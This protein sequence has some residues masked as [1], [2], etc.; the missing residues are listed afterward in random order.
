[1][2]RLSTISCCPLLMVYMTLHLA[3]GGIYRKSHLK[4]FGVPGYIMSPLT[5]PYFS[6][7]TCHLRN[8]QC[9]GHP[10][11][12][13]LPVPVYH[14]V[15]MDQVLRF[16]RSQ[17]IY[18]HGFRLSRR[19]VH[20]YVCK[21]RL[22]QHGLLHEAAMIDSYGEDTLGMDSNAP[23]ADSE[24][25]EEGNASVDST[26]KAREKFVAAALRTTKHRGLGSQKHE[27][28]TQM[29]RM[30]I[31][32]FL[33]D[34]VKSG[35]CA[36][37]QGVSPAYRK[38][39]FVKIFE[40][41]LSR[42]DKAMMERKNLRPVDAMAILRKSKAHRH[43]MG[44]RA[45]S[46]PGVG[47]DMGDAEAEVEVPTNFSDEKDPQRYIDAMEVRARLS[48]LFER[49][50]EILR[51]LYYSHPE[52]N[53]SADMFFIQT[54][55]VPPNRF[56]PEARMGPDRI[57]EAQQNSLF[58]NIL[59]SSERVVQ[60]HRQLRDESKD[61]AAG[62][63]QRTLAHLHQAWMELQDSVNCLIDKTK[64]PVQGMAAQRVE[65]GIKQQLEKKSG[66]F[67]KNMMGKRVNFAARSVIS[68]DPNIDTNEIGV[69][70][71]FATKLT[72]PE[73]VTSHNVRELA[74]AVVNGA[75]TWPGACAI[76]NEHGQVLNLRWK[77]V[78]ERESLAHQLLTPG[79]AEGG[80]ARNKK[81]HRHLANG[82]VVLMNRQPTL[83][84]PS[85]MGH[86]VRVLPGEKTIRMHYANC[87][88]Y[89]A[90]FDGDEMNMHFPQ[91]EIAR[92]EALQLA[93]TDHQYLSATQGGP[94]R[95]LIQDHLSISVS[96]C[97]KDTF[98]H[99]GDYHQ[100]VYSAL[101]P[102]SGHILRERIELLPP[103]IFKP[104]PLWTGKQV[105][106]TILRNITPPSSGGLWMDGNS[107]IK[108]SA[109]GPAGDEEGTVI[110]HDGVFVS[111]I[112]DK[113]HL[114]P[115][116]GGLIHS[117]HEVYG[118]T[119]A[120]KLLSSL[121]RLLTRTLNMRAFTC[122][123]DDLTLTPDGESSRNEK[124]S[125][126]DGTG[127]AVASEY[128]G[129]KDEKPT[130]SDPIL[131]SR[132]EEVMR[133][134]SKQ[135]NLDRLLNG[136]AAELSTD[137][138]KVCLPGGLEKPFPRNHMQSMTTSGAKGSQVN[139]NQISVNLGQQVLEGRRVP[140]MVNGKSLPCFKA[141]DTN[142]RAGG[143]IVNRFLTGVRPQ[144]YFFH[145]MAGREGLIDTAVKTSRSGYLQRCIIKGMEGL[146]VAY[147]TTVR[148]SDGTLV[149]F[150][151]GEDGLDITK[152][153]Y[154]DDFGFVLR[155]L[156]SQA[157]Q[158]Q[159]GANGAKGLSEDKSQV[160]KHMKSAIKHSKRGSLSAKD[161]VNSLYSPARTLFATSEKFF[162]KMTSYLSENKD[163]LVLGSKGESRATISPMQ[164]SRKTAETLMATKFMRSLVEPGEAVGIV[165][166][167]SIGEPSTQ[168][169]L[170]TFH[171][172][173]HSAKNVTLGIPRLREIL[174]TAARNIS[175]PSMTLLMQ[176]GISSEQGQLFAKSISILPLSHVIDAARV[177]ETVG[178]GECVGLAKLY[179]VRLTFF[180]LR[181]LQRMYGINVRAVLST[182]ENELLPRV[183]NAIAKEIKKRG[184]EASSATPELGVGSKVAQ[185]PPA[186]STR[187]VG[188]DD[189]DDD[190]DDDD[191]TAAKRRENRTETATYG[192]NDD[193]DDMIQQQMAREASPVD[194]DGFDEKG[195]LGGSKPNDDAE[196]D[197]RDDHG[198]PGGD[199]DE[200]AEEDVEGKYLGRIKTK[201]ANITHFRFD[202]PT[203]TTRPFTVDFTMEY[204]V[205]TPKLL[206]INIVQ[207]AVSK[208]VIQQIAGLR[209]CTFIPKE[210]I[211]PAEV[212]A[213]HTAG[214]NIRAMWEY[215]DCIR[216]NR[217]ITN[218]IAAVL[219][220][221]GVEAC[222]SNIIRELLDVFKSHNIAVDYRHLSL[223]ADYMTR[224]GGF[225]PFNRLGLAGNISPFTKMSFETTVSFLKDALIEGDWDDLSSPS[226]RIV[227]GKLGK[228][229]TG[230]FDVLARA[231]TCHED[232]AVMG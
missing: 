91:N 180:P 160:I 50:Q 155:N 135:E 76:E 112:L 38:D 96:L 189:D 184:T 206:M 127:L 107:K 88:T 92:A 17:C 175:T 5:I 62:R 3:H 65:D 179:K 142:L 89:N 178:Q 1:M 136:K 199:N 185:A 24:A 230:S 213:V 128:V 98:V 86:R 176:D 157:A 131:L 14:P 116:S 103:A 6:C 214:V 224:N 109:W 25:E 193:E 153:G 216:V 173:G 2:T 73:P 97:N 74:Q 90:D 120:G 194:D 191:A 133:D 212:P 60:V 7:D 148:D 108:G 9:P 156:K 93:D 217:I 144:E 126:A 13:E 162:D 165:A 140:L 11:H 46:D 177:I 29:R 27:G 57:S 101:R 99:R 15:F 32:Q 152:Q 52:G 221:Y 23:G 117:V 19:D 70:P 129:M 18:C 79:N 80:G 209:D 84:K 200:I 20:A 166:G 223:I 12:I 72:Y 94:L 95:G 138:T 41:A 63:S 68:P 31:K 139:A 159:L 26:I 203:E 33:S 81:V 61:E 49:E 187:R 44:E 150:L 222:R 40:R 51:L 167:Q 36:T 218:D 110:F 174:M 134:D 168:M 181:E 53:I 195:Q 121:G 158:L 105:I 190:V 154:L 115:S 82:D 141:F 143:Y 77:E 211:G 4:C 43:S 16:L 104:R 64:S 124:L 55:L 75:D 37:C 67:R 208:S 196:D 229:G 228:V 66:L 78:E 169:T 132:L 137:A 59:R 219:E 161:P 182:V 71:V 149:Q 201:H 47:S 34:I 125:V 10:G 113:S 69:P 39:R 147:D 122:G 100:L 183:L 186:S 232:A 198:K 42:K 85:I 164:P 35:K 111:G 28:A 45:Q 146:V 227:M 163:G 231:P 102:E 205:R 202:A 207:E 21:F 225:T 123:M 87:N 220:E 204:S 171:L 151:Y 118:P 114:G 119:I 106:T 170:N 197:R 54:I 192:P 30:V 48:L 210:R 130:A 8:A 58:K 226:G 188:D 215:F 56:R 145:L 83:H 172:A 22:L